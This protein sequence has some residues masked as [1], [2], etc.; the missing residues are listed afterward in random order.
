MIVIL[1]YCTS[2]EIYFQYFFR[3]RPKEIFTLELVCKSRGN[4]V[5]EALTIEREEKELTVFN[6]RFAVSG[7]TIS[8]KEIFFLLP[9]TVHFD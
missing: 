7:S 1:V 5:I 9:S 8:E 4:S 6:Q 2:R 3:V